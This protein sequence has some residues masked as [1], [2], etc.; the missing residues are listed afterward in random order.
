MMR[1]FRHDR[2]ASEARSRNRPTHRGFGYVIFEGLDFLIDWGLREVDGPKN[3]ASVA[4]AA[5]LIT[6]YHPRILV[7]E[8]VAAKDCRRCRRVLELV[9]ALEWYGRERGLTVRK[10][11]QSRVKRIF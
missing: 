6:R 5:E 10:I 8:D 9:D 11:A 7:L 1:I 4:A 2:V 3:K